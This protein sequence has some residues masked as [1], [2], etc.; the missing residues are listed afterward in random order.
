[1]SNYRSQ[2]DASQRAHANKIISAAG[3]GKHSAPFGEAG[4]VKPKGYKSGGRVGYEEGGIVEEMMEGETS[5]P[6]LDRPARG[7]KGGATTVNVIIAQKEPSAGMGA[8]PLP[9]MPPMAPPAPPVPP[10]GAGGPPMPPEMPMRKNGGRVN[11]D[12][13]AGGGLGRLEKIRD[14][15]KN[16]GKPAKTP[17]ND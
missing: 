13:G 6:R 11:T 12:S 2:A 3:G 10:M 5:A 17:K 4:K 9:P 8:A 14:Y 7:K 16:A 1:M 15:G